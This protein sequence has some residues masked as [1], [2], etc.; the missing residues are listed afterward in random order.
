MKLATFIF[1]ARLSNCFAIQ[2]L[3]N[4]DYLGT[5]Y[6]ALR[7]DPHADLKDPGFRQPV[8]LL[9][10]NTVCF[11]FCYVIL[12]GLP[13]PCTCSPACTFIKSEVRGHSKGCVIQLLFYKLNFCDSFFVAVVDYFLVPQL[14]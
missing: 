8:I 12:V 14:L 13:V 11:F 2:K 9:T 10:Y 7:G 3:T 5:G 1:L 4:I 6:D